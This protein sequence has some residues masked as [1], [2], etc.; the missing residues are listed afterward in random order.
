M[1]ESVNFYIQTEEYVKNENIKTFLKVCNSV[2][3]C[4]CKKVF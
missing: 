3:F 1:I 4:D 2:Q